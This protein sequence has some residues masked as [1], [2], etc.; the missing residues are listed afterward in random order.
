MYILL[1]LGNLEMFFTIL[2]TIYAEMIME[3][4]ILY[5]YTNALINNLEFLKSEDFISNIEQGKNY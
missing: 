1:H 4:Y 3:N 5:F 2:L